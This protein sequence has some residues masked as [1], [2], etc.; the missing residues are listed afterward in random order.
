METI[1]KNC[2][3]QCVKCSSENINYGVLVYEGE[4]VYY[5]YECEDCN[6]KGNEY[7]NLIY[8]LSTTRIKTN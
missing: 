3:G 8:D 2:V 4:Y 7:Y 1:E 5:P 6:N